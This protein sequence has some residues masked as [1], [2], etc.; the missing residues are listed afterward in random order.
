MKTNTS[1]SHKRFIHTAYQQP[2][3]CG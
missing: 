1:R 2:L 3:K